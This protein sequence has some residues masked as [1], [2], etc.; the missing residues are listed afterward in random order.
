MGY[1][2]NNSPISIFGFV[3]YSHFHIATRR[4]KLDARAKPR[5]YLE[6]FDEQSRMYLPHIPNVTMTKHATLNEDKFPLV[7]DSK[8]EVFFQK[9]MQEEIWQFTENNEGESSDTSSVKNSD[10]PRMN[11]ILNNSGAANNVEE[12]TTSATSKA[13]P[14]IREHVANDA[15][16]QNIISTSPADEGPRYPTRER[17]AWI[18]FTINGLYRTYSDDERKAVDAIK[19]ADAAK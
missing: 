2:S 17:K 4:S 16:D 8:P 3:A 10:R 5:T 1:I 12:L 15:S 11:L 9:G 18:K 6:S 7:K 13:G 14:M 19:G